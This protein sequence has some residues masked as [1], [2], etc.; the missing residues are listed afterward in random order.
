MVAQ[1]YA[2]TVAGQATSIIC[3]KFKA[4]DCLSFIISVI[5]SLPVSVEAKDFLLSKR[6]AEYLIMGVMDAGTT[7]T[8]THGE[9]AHYA[10]LAEQDYF[11]KV[12]NAAFINADEF[13]QRELTQKLLSLYSYNNQPI[14]EDVEF[15]VFNNAKLL[16]GALLHAIR[17][18]YNAFFIFGDH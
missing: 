6:G 16:M 2:V 17:Y 7:I 1:N 15:L 18:N 10:D 5:Q 13:K 9:K 14:N 4:F 11:A 3:S 8:L 12:F